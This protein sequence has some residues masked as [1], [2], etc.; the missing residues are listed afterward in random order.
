LTKL[1]NLNLSSFTETLWSAERRC[2][3]EAI[4]KMKQL[5]SLKVSKNLFE[6]ENIKYLLEVLGDLENLSLFDVGNSLSNLEAVRTLKDK[7]KN[8]TISNCLNVW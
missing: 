8:L 3:Y 2:F 6:P 5:T 4:R 7:F 1:R